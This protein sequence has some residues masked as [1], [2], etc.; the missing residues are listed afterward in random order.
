MEDV[1]TKD[2]CIALAL[3][4]APQ[5]KISSMTTLQ[6][7][8]ARLQKFLIPME[9][10]FTLN[11]HGSDSQEIRNTQS[12]VYY[13][14]QN[15]DEGSAFVLTGQGESKV[16]QVIRDKLSKICTSTE[17]KEINRELTRLAALRAQEARD[18]EHEFLLVDV[19]DRSKLVGRIN[20]TH[21]ELF[22]LY[23][24]IKKRYRK[25]T[26]DIT[27]AGLI[28]YAYY[29]SKYLKE[30]RFKNIEQEGYTYGAYM[31]D[32]YF[33][34]ELENLVPILKEQQGNPDEELLDKYYKRF[35]SF[36]KGGRYPFALDNPDLKQ[37][38]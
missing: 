5:H 27:L 22:D 35:T 2:E 23:N 31:M 34:K 37:I 20:A 28:E 10:E 4:Y 7:T 24:D 13:E 1:L 11:E 36:A 9:V 3:Y 8:I 32:F 18:D 15:Y 14:R 25:T 6:K 38:I 21:I 17:L 12:T 16:Q 33:L 19:E 30:K 26:A 29:L